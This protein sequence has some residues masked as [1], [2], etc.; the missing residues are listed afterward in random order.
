ML[1]LSLL[2][3]QLRAYVFTQT[4]CTLVCVV[5]ASCNGVVSLCV[6][7][8]RCVCTMKKHFTGQ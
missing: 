6:R 2:Y 5:S 4:P 3:T 8:D 1:S 7:A